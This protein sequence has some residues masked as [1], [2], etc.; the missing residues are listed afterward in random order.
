M[1]N[2]DIFF[3]L[4]ITMKLPQLITYI[5]IIILLYYEFSE[6]VCLNMQMRHYLI[7]YALICIHFQNIHRIKPGSKFLFHFV[8]IL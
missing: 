8:D 3:N 4:Y 7:K 5:K 1:K 2:R 6:V